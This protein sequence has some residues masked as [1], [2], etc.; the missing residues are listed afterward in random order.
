MRGEASQVTVQQEARLG[1]ES[2]RDGE[3]ID[4]VAVLCDEVQRLNPTID[5]HLADFRMRRPERFGQMLH[6]LFALKIDA[7][8]F[9]AFV[10]LEKIV[11]PAVKEKIRRA[12]AQ[13]ICPPVENDLWMRQRTRNDVIIALII[14]S[15]FWRDQ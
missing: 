5:L 4:R 7:H 1:V 12:H 2:V 8:N 10:A 13:I 3:Q 6:R 14:V 9:P 15:Y 11:Q